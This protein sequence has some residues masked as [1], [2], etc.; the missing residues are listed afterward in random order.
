M[1]VRVARVPR[2][3]VEEPVRVAEGATVA[4]VLRTLKIPPDAV[5][6]VRNEEPVPLDATLAEGETLKIITVFSGG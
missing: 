4:Q 5:L 6:V 1:L 3:N 2:P